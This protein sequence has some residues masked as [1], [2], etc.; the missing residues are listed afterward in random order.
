MIRTPKAVDSRYDNAPVLEHSCGHFTLQGYSRA[1]VQT[2][3]RIPEYKIIFDH[4]AHPWEFYNT[5]HLALTHTHADHCNGLVSYV[6][7]RHLFRLTKPTIYV[8]PHTEDTIREVIDAWKKLNRQSFEF[9]LVSLPVGSDVNYTNQLYLR[10][11][12]T[13]HSIETQGY[14]LF[15]KVEKLLAK[16][17]GLDP[18]EISSK[19][20]GGDTI[21][22]STER[23]YFAFCAD[24]AIGVLEQEPW[25]YKVPTLVLECTFLS[26]DERETALRT[27]HVHIDDI[28]ARFDRFEN[29]NLVLSH[30]STRY[31][32]QEVLEQLDRLLPT[33]LKDKVIA[34][35]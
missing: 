29:E 4:G 11:F 2:Y 16:F 24:T 6:A 17:Q 32:R 3:W 21:T 14:F 12:A 18:K 9:E 26:E 33:R 20:S 8:P 31:S 27:K 10:P 5:A 23:P 13:V 28:I 22:E 15:E 1:A 34:W 25:L 30:F 7:T 19:K 35:I